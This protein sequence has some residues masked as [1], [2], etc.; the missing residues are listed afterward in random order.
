MPK[1][2][3]T[4]D[5]QERESLVKVCV[6]KGFGSIYSYHVCHKRSKLMYL[7]F[8]IARMLSLMEH[9]MLFILLIATQTNI[10]I[11]GVDISEWD[12]WP[13]FTPI[14]GINKTSPCYKASLDYIRLLN[15]SLPMA[16]M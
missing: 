12:M 16:T 2:Y 13:M 15:E 10:G 9:L 1:K 5:R 3:Y 6:A 4:I 8:Q 7:L 11:N 14:L